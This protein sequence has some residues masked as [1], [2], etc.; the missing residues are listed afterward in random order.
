[1]KW[2]LEKQDS[3]AWTEFVAT[4]ADSCEHDN[5]LLCSI[6]CWEILEQLVISQEGLSSMEFELLREL[7]LLLL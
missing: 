2:I 3:M 4:I 7:F 5:E 6:K 1:M